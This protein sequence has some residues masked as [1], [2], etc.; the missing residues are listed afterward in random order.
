MLRLIVTGEE[1]YDEATEEF[2]TFDDIVLELE[3]SLAA[4]SK[5]ESKFGK[6]FLGSETKTDE[7]VR[8][9]VEAMML[10]PTFSSEMFDKFTKKNFDDINEYIGSSQSATTFVETRHDKARRSGEV[11]TAE[12]IYFW[13]VSYNVPFE[14][15]HWNLNRL[16]ALLRICGIKNSKEK[17]M[18]KGEVAARNREINAARRAQLG[19]SG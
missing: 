6:P 11:V 17:K 3:H 18:S 13:M 19:T 10:T 8:G 4:L 15:E 14:C 5:W 7:E 1:F 2:V 16:F 12:L 9:Y